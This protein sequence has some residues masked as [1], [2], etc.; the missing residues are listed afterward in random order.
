MNKK[1]T[2]NEKKEVKKDINDKKNTQ[3]IKNKSEIKVL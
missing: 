3:W 2:R 1:W